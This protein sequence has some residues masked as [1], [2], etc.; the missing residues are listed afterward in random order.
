MASNI[1]NATFIIIHALIGHKFSM[2]LRVFGSQIG[3]IV[4]LAFITILSSLNSDDWQELFLAL[5][6]TGI[7][8]IN[9]F[10]AVFQGRYKCTMQ[11]LSHLYDLPIFNPHPQVAQAPC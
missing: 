7:V 11:W 10:S 2:N 6:L 8:L 4:V 9:A 5:T 3:M 1:P